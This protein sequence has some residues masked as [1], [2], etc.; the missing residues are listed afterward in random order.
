MVTLPKTDADSNVAEKEKAYNDAVANRK[1]AEKKLLA[2]QKVRR[3]D[4][5]TYKEEFPELVTLEQNV[6]DAKK[7]EADAKTALEDAQK[8][9]QEKDVAFA[10]A[11][12]DYAE[13][14][15]DYTIAKTDYDSF[16]DAER[17]AEEA[18]K[19]AMTKVA[20]TEKSKA[21]KTGDSTDLDL[22]ALG[23]AGAAAALAA[24]RKRKTER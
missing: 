18:R 23:L 16:V 8:D 19:A 12:A 17:K 6:T 20:V 1:T 13:A 3:E 4:P 21:P 5:S 24:S 22:A 11:K 2:A 14:L 10:N 7:A 9:L 15:A